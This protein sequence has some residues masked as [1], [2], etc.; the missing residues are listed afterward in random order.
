MTSVYVPRDAGAQSLGADEVAQAIAAHARSSNTPLTLVRNGSRGAYALEPLV[1]VATPQGRVAYGPVTVADVPGLFA[2]G[3]LAGGAHPLAHGLTEE[4]AWFKGQQRLTFARVGIVDPSSVADYVKN[5]G[6]AGLTRALAMEPGAVVA[7]VLASGLR[8]RGGAAFPTGI[9]WKTVHEQPAGQKYVTCNADEGDSGTF[10]DRMLMEG[11]PLSLIEGMTIGGLAVGA[12]QGYVYLRAEYPHAHRALNTAIAAAYQAHYLGDDVAGSGRRF[13]L[14]VRLGAG[15]YICGE[16]T[17]MLESL[18]GKRGEVRV[19]PPLPAIKG[20]F[21][22]PT[23]VNNVITLASVPWILAQGAEAYANYG[24]G[25]SR[26]TLPIQLAGNLKNCGLVERAFGLSLRELL[27]DY[28]GGS[29]TGRP[30]RTVQIGGPLGAYVPAAQFDVA[31]D[32]ESLSGIGALLGH[33]GI[34][35]FDDT[36]DMARMA[37]YAMEFCALESC[38]KCTPCRIGSTRGVEVI[39]RILAGV[40]G[41]RNLRLLEELCETMVQGSLC[42]LGGMAPFPVQSA[43]KHFREDFLAAPK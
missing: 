11:D 43:L 2:A 15:A 10:A 40:D 1:E 7:A 4:I 14:E 39:D 18:E 30:I 13:H 9:K 33:G 20:L 12:T 34:V 26:G 23:I 25:K 32:Y 38:G 36:V 8:G 35:A 29:A 21:G 42:G 28:G 16:E 41:A 19:R 3:F 37:R 5:G 22:K 6:Y 24:T 27:Y 17:S 31:V